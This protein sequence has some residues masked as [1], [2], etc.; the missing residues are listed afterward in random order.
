[1][2]S[3][4]RFAAESSRDL[5]ETGREDQPARAQILDGDLARVLLVDRRQMVEGDAVQLHL[6]QLVHRQLAARVRQAD[7]DAIDGSGA[8][9]GR[10]VLDRADDAGIQD[11]C[12]DLGRIG[13]DEADDLDAQLVASVEHLP[14]QVHR[15]R[16]WCRRAAAA[17]A[18]ACSG[19]AIRTGDASR[20]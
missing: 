14:R 8:D 5:L 17:R 6:E 18:A 2:T 16:R 12:A 10:N 3:I 7:D 15:S 11:R 19:S 20:E 1:M 9:D 4:I 13:I